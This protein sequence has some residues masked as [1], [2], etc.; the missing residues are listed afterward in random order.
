MKV[1]IHLY[2]QSKPVEVEAVR[3]CYTKGGLYC[4]LLHDGTVY[5]FPLEHVFRITEAGLDSA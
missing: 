2:T 5:K 4:V 1:S 3:N